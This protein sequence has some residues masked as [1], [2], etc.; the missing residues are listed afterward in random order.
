MRALAFGLIAA[1]GL[2][3]LA[4]FFIIAPPRAAPKQWAPAIDWIGST[5]QVWHDDKRYV[6]C[7]ILIG[8]VEQSISC[9]PDEPPRGKE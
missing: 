4:L 2:G 8:H 6:T 7:W 9:L 1:A 3:L 5:P